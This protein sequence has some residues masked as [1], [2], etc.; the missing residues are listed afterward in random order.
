MDKYQ[1]YLFR[2]LG[3]HLASNSTSGAK[4]ISFREGKITI[5]QNDNYHFHEFK[6]I[7]SHP[8]LKE[9]SIQQG[10]T[11]LIG[12]TVSENSQSIKLDFDNKVSSIRIEFNHNL[13]DQIEI[14]IEF[15]DADRAA[16]DAKEEKEYRENL[17]KLA[18]IKIIKGD[19][20]INVLFNPLDAE[21]YSYSVV[22]LFYSYHDYTSRED[23]HQLMG[24]FKSEND[25]FFI[26][27]CNLGYGHYSLILKQ[28][29]K[30]NQIM[31]ES[32]R[33]EFSIERE[34]IPVHNTS[35]VRM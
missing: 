9:V 25:K 19:F 2:W 29:N 30:E 16:W 15:I 10:D 18:S 27:I 14:P 31:Y 26:P 24:S 6:L 12:E 21:K 4:D 20:F 22:T 17:A 23:I 3:V 33:I 35:S 5:T 32:E 7:V 34:S 8:Q 1:Q 13:A 11:K 28:F